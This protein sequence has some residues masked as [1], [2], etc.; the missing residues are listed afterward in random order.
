M[1]R[2]M[3][4]GRKTE[5]RQLNGQIAQLGKKFHIKTPYN[6]VLTELILGLEESRQTQAA[7]STVLRGWQR[8]AS[9]VNL[10]LHPANEVWTREALHE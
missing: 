2:D 3:E 9:A 8:K 7:P 4:A 5:I 6:S 1:L 10:A